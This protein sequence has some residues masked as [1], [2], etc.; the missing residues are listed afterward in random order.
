MKDLERQNEILGL[1]KDSRFLSNTQLTKKLSVSEATIRRD[2]SKLAKKGLIRRLRGGAETIEKFIRTHP[3][4]EPFDSENIVNFEAKR[5]I[6]QK[7]AELC[8]HEESIII[9]GGTTTNLMVEFLCDHKLQILTNALHTAVDL[10]KNSNNRVILPGGEV[11][12]EQN[13]IVSPFENDTIQQYSASK[14][15]M[16]TQG[17]SKVGLTQWDPLLIR[18]QQK[19]MNQ[20]EKL[21]ILADSSKFNQKGSFILCPLNRVDVVITDDKVDQDSVRLLES[22][23]V[24]LMVV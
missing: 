8:D 3:A 21:V 5:R 6:A 9:D 13:V 17:I 16:A 14:L 12:R 20:A 11:F 10:L 24:D 4:W 15:F 7:A 2:L 18:A 1:L 23:G 19:L 22:E